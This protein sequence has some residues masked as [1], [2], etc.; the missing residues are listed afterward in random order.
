MQR[1]FVPAENWEDNRVMITNDDAHHISRV[2]RS[3]PGDV[4]ICNH[5]DG[6]AVT[7]QITDITKNHVQAVI[8]ERLGES[9]ELPVNVTI[10]QGLPKSDK[11]ELVLQKGTE[12]GATAFVPVQA[13]RSVVAWDDKKT[14]KKMNRFSRIVKEASEQ[15]HRN[16]IPFIQPVRAIKTLVDESSE[17][18]LKLFAFEEEAK[19]EEY[20]S[21]GMLVSEINPGDRV[22]IVIGPEGGFSEQEAALLKQN[23]F[24]PIRLGPRILR[25]E[26]A[27][28]YALASISY[29]FEELGCRSCRQ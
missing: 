23:E 26:T 27:A 18:D 17:Y 3:K 2:M 11:F 24:V 20:Q 9:A 7:C 15:C 13:D 6:K 5:P 12:L 28:L 29:H 4:I 19:T 14:E 22:L 21:F 16:K 1:Y 25:T 10:A 8:K